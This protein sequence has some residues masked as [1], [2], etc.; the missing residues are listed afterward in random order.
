MNTKD[1]HREVAVLSYSCR[2]SHH[3][4]VA[5]Q[6]RRPGDVKFVQGELRSLVEQMSCFFG[7][8]MFE[9]IGRNEEKHIS[10][11]WSWNTSELSSSCMFV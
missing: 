10:S 4:N 11:C 3:I 8:V 1:G 7:T 9:R 6:M 2:P 5:I